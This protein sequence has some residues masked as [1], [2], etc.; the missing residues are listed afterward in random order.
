MI[1][2][3]KRQMLEELIAELDEQQ[4]AELRGEL[5]IVDAVDAEMSETP[6]TVTVESNGQA[7]RISYNQAVKSVVMTSAQAI[8]LAF[9]ILQSCGASIDRSVWVTPKPSD[10]A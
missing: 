2:P 4:L 9:L 8:E 10:V 1:D 6:L 5:L 7:V 3:E